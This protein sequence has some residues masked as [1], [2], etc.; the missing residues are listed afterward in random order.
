MK[1]QKKIGLFSSYQFIYSF[2]V[3]AEKLEENTKTLLILCGIAAIIFTVQFV[4]PFFIPIRLLLNNSRNDRMDSV[5]FVDLNAP[6]YYSI[7]LTGG[8]SYEVI[9]TTNPAD[10]TDIILRVSSIPHLIVGL[11]V[12]VPSYTGETLVF[13]PSYSGLYYIM[14]SSY[15]G[16]AK[17]FD[18]IV[19]PGSGSSTGPVVLVIDPIGTVVLFL[20]TVLF[21]ILPGYTA[22]LYVFSF[23]SRGIHSI[24][25][26]KTRKIQKQKE[27]ERRILMAPKTF[28]DFTKKVRRLNEN[29]LKANKQ[30]NYA[31]AIQSWQESIQTLEKSKVE[32]LK[33]DPSLPPKIDKQIENLKLNIQNTEIE[34]LYREGKSHIMKGEQS[35]NKQEY[36]DARISVNQGLKKF[37]EAIKIA[38]RYGAEQ[39]KNHLKRA[40]KNAWQQLSIYQRKLSSLLDEVEVVKPRF[41]ESDLKQ[42]IQTQQSSGPDA[43]VGDQIDD[44]LDIYRKWEKKNIGKPKKSDTEDI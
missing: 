15:P 35:A 36:S 40:F 44:L 38:D 11:H 1:L 24:T 9:V 20:P 19:Q 42:P 14:V 32:A 6:A 3:G 8:Q 39:F 23:F 33:F 5:A 4:F 27:E 21:L 10:S 31:K 12:D 16:G 7:T 29:A 37:E 41:D 2:C 13:T 18:I 17:D 28:E 22:L 43:E 34:A 30:A 26:R 25:S